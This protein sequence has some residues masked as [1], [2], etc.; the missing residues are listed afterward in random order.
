MQILSLREQLP[1]PWVIQSYS[2]IAGQ[3]VTGEWLWSLKI[4]EN[5]QE[6]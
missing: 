1:D 5:K 4:T 3:P 2:L 6:S